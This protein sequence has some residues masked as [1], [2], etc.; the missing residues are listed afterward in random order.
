MATSEN[1]LALAMSAEEYAASCGL[2]L[3]YVYNCCRAG[4]LPGG[5]HPVKAGRRYLISRR[6]VEAWLEG[7]KTSETLN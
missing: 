2:S 5:L 6:A 3:T 1:P 4:T 7:N